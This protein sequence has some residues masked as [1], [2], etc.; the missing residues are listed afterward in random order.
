[1]ILNIQIQIQ[2]DESIT[3]FVASPLIEEQQPFLGI[4]LIAIW[5]NAWDGGRRLWTKAARQTNSS[6]AGQGIRKKVFNADFFT[7][8]KIPLQVKNISIY[9][10]HRKQIDLNKKKIKN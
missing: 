5:N 4:P 9:F 7:L 6:G 2:V 10:K 1:M 3:G 8:P